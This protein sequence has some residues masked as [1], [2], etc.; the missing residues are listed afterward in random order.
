MFKPLH[1]QE[2]W[3]ESFPLA[4]KGIMGDENGMIQSEFSGISSWTLEYSS[5][6]LSDPGDYAKTVST[7]GGR[8]EACDIDGEVV[9]RSE[10]INIKGQAN[11]IVEL[12]AAETGSGANTGTKYMNVFYRVDEGDELPFSGN[13]MNSGNWGTLK[14]RQEGI[15][16]NILQV[17]CYIST[18]YAA[19]KVILDEVK[20]WSE[21]AQLP[22]VNPSDV[23]IN[24]L[25][26]DP[27]PPVGL[28]EVEYIELYNTRDFPV[29]TE[30]WQLRI[31]GVAKKLQNC[32]IETDGYLLLCANGSLDSLIEFGSFS[33]IS[34]FQGL[35][36]KGAVVEI[37]DCDG[38]VIDRIDYSDTWF[39][40][41][42]KSSGGWSL[43]R[44][45]PRR[46]CNQTGN[47]KASMH[48]LGGTPGSRNSVFS[49]NRDDTP[50]FVKW[51]VAVSG[52]EVEVAFSEPID[53]VLLND[54]ANYFISELGNPDSIELIADGQVILHF[55]QT[56][57][58]EKI[59]SLNMSNLADECSNNLSDQNLEIQWNLIHPG[60]LLI[61]EILFDPY[62]G[63]EDYVEIY[64][65]SGKLIDLSR[66]L[67]ANRNNE[68]EL[69]QVLELTKERR[70]LFPGEYLAVTKDTN[71]VF[72][73]YSVQCP[74]CF[75]QMDRIPS[76]S[77]DE[78]RVVLM[79]SEKT[80]IDELFYT[81]NM[82]SPFLSD[83]EGVSLERLSLSEQTNTQGNWHSAAGD[84]G[85]G[86]PGYQNS[87]AEKGIEGKPVIIFEPEAFSPNYDGYNDE[88]IIHYEIAEPG[89]V[90]NI[91]IFD[92]N[93]RFIHHCLKNEILGTT[94]KLTWNG[95]DETG[96]LLPV[97]IYVVIMELFNSKGE[98]Y[99][100][101]D[102]VVLTG[103]M[104]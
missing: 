71:S 21:Q 56:L 81:A 7:S 97:G 67:L 34:G 18:H 47:W 41:D 61:N 23:V 60:D 45:D 99:R 12:T 14:A 9:W 16:G 49:E 75:L 52:T 90:T 62:P 63:G 77:N 87:L 102:G 68:H 6:E 101:K 10:W 3:R 26:T 37:L 95:E 72:P 8:F 64:N 86:T 32:L 84:A 74:P 85:Y 80:V 48:T 30:N 27:Y 88:Y 44:I 50:P 58:D 2:I 1:A 66:L 82:H 39:G 5:V 46:N 89:F 104:E 54:A 79:N 40:D 38:K 20:V 42:S 92:A 13:G 19:D 11:V 103:H 35:L 93:G 36:N 24:E 15:A 51:A 69:N 55:S 4:G 53:S 100:F 91:K 83:T 59:F 25:M 31:N 70:V 65:Q 98:V 22:P 73:W 57:Q 43:E 29:R 78:G 33:G 28:P 76:F 94:G 17:V 96:R